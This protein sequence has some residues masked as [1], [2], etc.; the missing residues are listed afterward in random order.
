M[1][2]NFPFAS[3]EMQAKFLQAKDLNLKLVRFNSYVNLLM[4]YVFSIST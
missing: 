2:S 3:Y 4:A 1:T